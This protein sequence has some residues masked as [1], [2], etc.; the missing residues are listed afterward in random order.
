MENLA[1][2][3]ISNP[4]EGFRILKAHLWWIKHWFSALIPIAIRDG[5]NRRLRQAAKLWQ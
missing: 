4:N 3:Y 5:K 1:V 2:H